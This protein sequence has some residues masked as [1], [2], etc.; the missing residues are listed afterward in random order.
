LNPCQFNGILH[1]ARERLRKSLTVT[2]L[3]GSE[4]RATPRVRTTPPTHLPGQRKIR[5]SLHGR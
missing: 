2:S 5:Q 4:P 1:R 3:T